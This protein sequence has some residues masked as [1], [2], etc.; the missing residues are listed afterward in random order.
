M[1][2]FKVLTY[3][4]ISKYYKL[5]IVASNLQPSGGTLPADV[6]SLSYF[7]LTRM[8]DKF[9]LIP[10]SEIKPVVEFVDAA[11]NTVKRLSGYF[12]GDNRYASYSDNGDADLFFVNGRWYY[13]KLDL[14]LESLYYYEPTTRK[15]INFVPADFPT[16]NF[17]E[18]MQV[19]GPGLAAFADKW[20][21]V[22][23]GVCGVFLGAPVLQFGR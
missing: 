18:V 3:T 12:I 9:P 8:V 14:G 22:V 15:W 19:Y 7:T 4:K 20:E 2:L 17:Y 5:S 16:E 13:R 6:A 21:K 11:G 1:A 10:S 23:V